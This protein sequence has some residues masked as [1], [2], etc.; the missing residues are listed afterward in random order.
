MSATA[1]SPSS[2]LHRSESEAIASPTAGAVAVGGA[3]TTAL[4]QMASA[5]AIVRGVAP[6][7]HAAR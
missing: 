1:G 2:R 6:Q 7:P 4:A 3:K 5:A